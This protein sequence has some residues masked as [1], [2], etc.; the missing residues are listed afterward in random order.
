M[1]KASYIDFLRLKNDHRIVATRLVELKKVLRERNQ[2]RLCLYPNI[3]LEMNVLKREA[4]MLC[5]ISA[6][7]HNRN[8]P[9]QEKRNANGRMY[10][11]QFESLDAQKAFVE[12]RLRSYLKEKV[13]EVATVTA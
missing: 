7:L 6:H 9:G 10:W 4:T 12:D 1:S 8:H 11:T 5:C 2:P 3:G 13:E